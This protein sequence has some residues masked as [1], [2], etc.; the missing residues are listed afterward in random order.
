MAHDP[1]FDPTQAFTEAEVRAALGF[2]L[3]AEQA[4]AQA[5]PMCDPLLFYAGP[6]DDPPPPPERLPPSGF[7][8]VAVSDGMLDLLAL[9]SDDAAARVWRLR[10]VSA[11]EGER[12]RE[13][14]RA[15]L[16][17]SPPPAP[18]GGVAADGAECASWASRPGLRVRLSVGVRAWPRRSYAD[19]VTPMPQK[20]SRPIPGGRA[21][22]LTERLWALAAELPVE[23]VPIEAIEEFDAVCWFDAESPPTCRN[24]ARH[25]RRIRDADL[26]YPVIL[27]ADG[28]LMD[29]GHRLAK[30]WLAG[31]TAVAAV[32]FAV[33]PTPDYVVP[34]GA[35]LGRPSSTAP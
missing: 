4:E 20:H 6:P 26:S 7:L 10:G 17:S 9:V 23:R 14:L 30:A 34:D 33:D 28:R 27:S 11:P 8:C 18:Q 31:E 24:V 19:A 22:W 16:A 25:A 12:Q 32:R 2:V 21:V 15:Q 13:A 3:S 29:G 35:S 1:R 5:R